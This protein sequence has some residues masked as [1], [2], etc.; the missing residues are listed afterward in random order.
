MTPITFVNYLITLYNGLYGVDDMECKNKVIDYLPP[1]EVCKIIGISA[2][3]T[4]QIT[5]WIK[6][7]RIAG[8]Y[9]FGKTVAIPTNWVKSECITRGIDW[10]GVQ[11]EEGKVGVSLKDYEPL[12]DYAKKNNIGYG[13]IHNQITR[14]TFNKDFVRFDTSFGIRK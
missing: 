14:G 13:T 6:D 1:K 9:R 2:K 3:S 10:E 8:V 11:V 7:G 12:I 5:R 4:A